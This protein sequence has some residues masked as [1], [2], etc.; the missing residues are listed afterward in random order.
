MF[1]H[2]DIAAANYRHKHT[3]RVRGQLLC[4]FAAVRLVSVHA[5]SPSPPFR[6]CG[7]CRIFHA[8]GAPTGGGT[9]LHR[10]G[11]SCHHGKSWHMTMV[12][13]FVLVFFYS[14]SSCCSLSPCVSANDP[15]QPEQRAAS[16][17]VFDKHSARGFGEIYN[18]GG[19][20]SKWSG[21]ARPGLSCLVLDRFVLRIGIRTYYAG[22]A[23]T[24]QTDEHLWSGSAVRC[25]DGRM[26]PTRPPY[27]PT[28]LPTYIIDPH[29]GHTYS[30]LCST[31]YVRGGG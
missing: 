15:R 13:F 14:L 18:P 26:L 8:L 24:R 10:N 17:P 16:P 4:T 23:R 5:W 12:V 29:L 25:N 22:E 6:K 9:G 21:L 11:L 30:V 20:G 1:C 7:W 31:S 2:T 3:C 27:L 28:Y 19:G